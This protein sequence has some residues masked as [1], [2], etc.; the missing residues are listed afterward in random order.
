MATTDTWISLDTQPIRQALRKAERRGRDLKPPLTRIMLMGVRSVIQ[1]FEQEGRPDHWKAVKSG[2]SGKILQVTGRLKGS[3][4]PGSMG[5]LTHVSIDDVVIGTNVVYAA[6]HNY[7]SKDGYT[8]ARVFMLWQVE[9]VAWAE[10]EL[11]DHVV[12]DRQPGRR[13]A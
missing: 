11:L 6:K 8:D 7:G 2:R 4:T 9:N 12:G 1:N 3:I 10:V 5:S 13:A